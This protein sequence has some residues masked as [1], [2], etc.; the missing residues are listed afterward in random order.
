MI[1]EDEPFNTPY[2]NSITSHQ[3]NPKEVQ[4]E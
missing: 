3:M 2:S 1:D 4:G